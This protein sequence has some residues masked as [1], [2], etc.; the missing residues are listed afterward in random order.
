LLKN[1]KI[2][3]NLLKNRKELKKTLRNFKKCQFLQNNG[4]AL[5]LLFKKSYKNFHQKS[6]LPNVFFALSERSESKGLCPFRGSV[7]HSLFWSKSLH[8]MIL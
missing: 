7:F 5:T 8:K 1:A 3:E 6:Q 4:I 2:C